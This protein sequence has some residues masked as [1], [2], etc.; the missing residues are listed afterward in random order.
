MSARIHFESGG[1]IEIVDISI[2][3]GVS[4]GKDVKI[5]GATIRPQVTVRESVYED[6]LDPRPVQ[7]V[8]KLIAQEAACSCI[9]ILGFISLVPAFEVCNA[10]VYDERL[11]VAVSRLVASVVVQVV[12]WTSILWLGQR[13]V[14]FRGKEVWFPVYINLVGSLSIYTMWFVIWGSPLFVCLLSFMGARV[15]GEL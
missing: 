15:E 3:L 10:L 14:L 4:I 1:E 13:L 11:R 5:H 12:T 9:P 8:W 6:I 7:S 2:G